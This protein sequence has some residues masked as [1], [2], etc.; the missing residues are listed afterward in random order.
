MA[1]H[2]VITGPMGAG[3]TAV[4][5]AL[6]GARRMPFSD[7]DESLLA[8]T[9]SNAREI[10]AADGVPH[11]HELE[12]RF[13]LDSIAASSPQV[14]AAAASIADDM[15]LLKRIVA[16]GHTLVMLDLA[17]PERGLQHPADHR[18]PVGDAEARRLHADRMRAAA[19]AGATVVS[20][21]HGLEQV[22]AT[23][24]GLPDPATPR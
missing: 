6:A 17:V 19:E 20:A 2:I 12:R 8:I 11:L 3:K 4:G 10:A 1:Q 22:L 24:T 9:G 13:V 15:P 16:E 23:L 21:D 7:S 18:R 14:I 5:R